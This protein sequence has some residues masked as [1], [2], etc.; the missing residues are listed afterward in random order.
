MNRLQIARKILISKAGVFFTHSSNK[1]PP[2][3]SQLP[4]LTLLLLT[5]ESIYQYKATRIRP[6]TSVCYDRS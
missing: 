3:Y 2:P 4:N 1:E 6:L 5:Y